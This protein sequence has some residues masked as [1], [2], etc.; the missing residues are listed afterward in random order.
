VLEEIDVPGE[1]YLD[2]ANSLLYF[3]P[4]GDMDG[5]SIR[6]SSAEEP[7]IE[8]HDAKH[9]AFKGLEL[10]YTTVSGVIAFPADH[11]L[12]EDC[13]IYGT[14]EKGMELDV[15][16]NLTVSGCEIYD[17]DDTG[18]RSY[19]GV[20]SNGRG[21]VPLQS[22]GNIIENTLFRDLGV[23]TYWNAGID[24][25][26]AGLQVRHCEFYN[27]NAAAYLNGPNTVFEYNYV[28]DVCLEEANTAAVVYATV[29]DSLGGMIRYNYFRDIGNTYNACVSPNAIQVGYLAVMP[30]I[31]GNAFYRCGLG[32]YAPPI[33]T[34]FG[35]FGQIENNL[36]ID[37]AFAADLKVWPLDNGQDIPL[38]NDVWL[39]TW[40]D[41]CFDV[42]TGDLWNADQWHRIGEQNSDFFSD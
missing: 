30:Q 11:I 3:Y 18:I 27:M 29:A 40:Y 37:A 38:K 41:V 5:A 15:V 10:C 33:K 19:R 9:M 8:L 26:D 22:G 31:Y 7:L 21:V 6:V 17:C 32:D 4:P 13:A 1:Y 42:T 16:T 23:A 2:R 28:H 39:L 35:Q 14:S 34:V 12:F 20:L 25:C 24:S 36:I